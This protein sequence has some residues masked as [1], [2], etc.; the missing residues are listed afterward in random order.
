MSQ[1][2]HSYDMPG[3]PEDLVRLVLPDV[4]HEDLPVLPCRH[5][6]VGALW[7]DGHLVGWTLHSSVVSSL[8]LVVGTHCYSRPIFQ[9]L[10]PQAEVA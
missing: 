1:D 6:T 9:T 4:Y 3:S 10:T 2:D 7:Y 8:Q 5:D